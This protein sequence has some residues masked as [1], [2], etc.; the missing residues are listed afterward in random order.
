[1]RG[2]TVIELLIAIVIAGVLLAIAVPRGRNQ[3]DRIAVQSA[4]GDVR[5]VLSFARNLALSAQLP[6]VVVVDSTTGTIAVKQWNEFIRSRGITHAHGVTLRATRDSLMYDAWGLGRGAANL[7]VI[8]R[9]RMVAETIFVSR[10]GR[11]R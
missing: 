11:I 7:S 9:K 6:V 4:R 10:L 8:L 2:Y 1:V 3:L 5:A